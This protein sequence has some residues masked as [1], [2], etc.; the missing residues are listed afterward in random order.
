MYWFM[1]S[2]SNHTVPPA[3]FGISDGVPTSNTLHP[4]AQ[5]QVTLGVSP[6]SK[7]AAINSRLHVLPVSV[8]EMA[9]LAKKATPAI[10]RINLLPAGTRSAPPPSESPAPQRLRRHERKSEKYDRTKI[11]RRSAWEAECR[12]QPYNRLIGRSLLLW[13][14][15]GRGER[16]PAKL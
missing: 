2:Y 12:D 16:I 7:T 11:L 13:A 10:P 4:Q 14:S 8:R 1:K 9:T 3:P 5:A 6:I 15:P